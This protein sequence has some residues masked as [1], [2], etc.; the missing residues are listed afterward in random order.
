[1]ILQKM[2]ISSQLSNLQ[3]KKCQIRSKKI[4]RTPKSTY[5]DSLKCTKFKVISICINSLKGASLQKLKF[6]D[7]VLLKI[8]LSLNLLKLYKKASKCFHKTRKL[9]LK[10]S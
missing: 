5:H 3:I 10:T 9:N 1:M 2:L 8:I 4:L 7:Q 6:E